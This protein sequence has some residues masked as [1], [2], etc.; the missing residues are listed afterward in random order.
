MKKGYKLFFG[1]SL[2]IGLA[3][4][5]IGCASEPKAPVLLVY[6]PPDNDYDSSIP[7]AQWATFL[8]NSSE[9]GHYQVTHFNGVELSPSWLQATTRSP[10][11]KVRIPSGSVANHVSGDHRYCESEI[12]FDYGDSVLG[13]FR[14]VRLPFHALAGRD[15]RLFAMSGGAGAGYFTIYEISQEREP[16]DDEQVLFVKPERFGGVIIVLDKSTNDERTFWLFEHNEEIRVIVPQG[17]HTIDVELHPLDVKRR[18]TIEPMGEQPRIFT[19]SSNQ[20]RYTL[21][22]QF[23][24]KG[25]VKYNLT[26]Q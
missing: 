22:V 11:I 9:N 21:A 13:N 18:A 19:V 5:F 8:I 1:V 16:N 20:V 17:E 2:A 14:N 26:Q 12:V 4:V 25:N 15:Y 23:D 3:I 24:R 6:D 7:R 10:D